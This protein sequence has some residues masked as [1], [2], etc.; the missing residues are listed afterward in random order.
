MLTFRLLFVSKQA[1]VS[2]RLLVRAR[3][4]MCVFVRVHVHV[5]G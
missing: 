1:E 3:V 4:C 5:R 2:F